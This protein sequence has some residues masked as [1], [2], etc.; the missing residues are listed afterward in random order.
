MLWSMTTIVYT[1]GACI[2]NP[3]PGG[4]AWA[5]PNGPFA[6]G[7]APESTNQ[8]MELTAALEALRAIPGPLEVRSDSEHVVK[9]INDRWYVKWEDNGWR[10]SK[11]KPVANDDL[12]RPI[13]GLV[14]QRGSELQFVWVKAHA[15]DPMNDLVDRL[16]T[17]AARTQSARSGTGQPEDLGPPDEP[18][19]GPVKGRGGPL[20]AI[21]GWRLIVVG[22]H[23]AELGGY[24]PDNPVAN[25]V[26]EKLAKIM[27]GLKEIHPDVVVLTGLG[28]GAGMLG[29][30]AAQVANVSYTVVEAHPNPDSVWQVASRLRYKQLVLAATKTI[31]MSA[32]A[33]R[34]KQ[35]AGKAMGIRDNALVAIA[36]GALVVWDGTDRQLAGVVN[37]LEKRI[38]DDVWIV[39]LG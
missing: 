35:E 25:T 4:W 19:R 1:D 32:K 12:W 13:V 7:A 27:T 34:S 39:G 36:D 11:K 38:P 3:G 37:S 30:E 18:R 2:N 10:N 28:L 29:A 22:H 31:T 24:E 33:P 23:A 6:S 14:H 8:R 21:E 20:G 15:D 16:A 17:E 9:G 5:V 26:R